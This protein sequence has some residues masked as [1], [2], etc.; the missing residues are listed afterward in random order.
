[1]KQRETKKTENRCTNLTTISSKINVQEWLL[2]ING[3]MAPLFA[4]HVL[5]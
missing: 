2:H 1:M 3:D 5:K 4:L